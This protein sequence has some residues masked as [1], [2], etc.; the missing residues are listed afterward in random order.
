[1]A[2][3]TAKTKQEIQEVI[4]MFGFASEREFISRAVKEK[5]MELKKLQFFLISEKVR[6]ELAKK[7]IE[8][9]DILKEIKS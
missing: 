3:L 5:L 1:M 6:R 7:G 8:P 2:Y 4:K 9:E